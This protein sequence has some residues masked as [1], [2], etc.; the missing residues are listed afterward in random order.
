M[1]KTPHPLRAYS[2]PICLLFCVLFAVSTLFPIVAS[3]VNQSGRV[4]PI[5][6]VFDVGIALICFL[7]FVLLVVL[8][9][10]PTGQPELRISQ[11]INE[12]LASIPL[13]LIA[14]YFLGPGLNWEVLLIGLGWRFWLLAMVTP[15]LVT[16]L[17]K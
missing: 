11:R 14:L 17:R 3:V 13:L 4:M 8:V 9:D 6:G 1:S 10:K 16:A 15:Y 2:K 5:A 12:Y 7:L